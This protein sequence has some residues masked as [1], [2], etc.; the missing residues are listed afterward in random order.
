MSTLK[1]KSLASSYKVTMDDMRQNLSKHDKLWSHTIHA[2]VISTI[3]SVLSH[4]LLRARSLLTG[5][6]AA[7][8]VLIATYLLA[9]LHGYEPSGSEPL[10]GF[11]I[12]WLGALIFDGVSALFHR[13]KR[14]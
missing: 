4:S 5:G 10:I 7:G 12:G 14:Y 13:R 9:R 8:I 2:P 6:V 3:A 1:K 11:F